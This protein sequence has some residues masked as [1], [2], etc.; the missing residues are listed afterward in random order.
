[1]TEA[2][3][4]RFRCAA[5]RAG[6]GLG[7]L[8]IVA[9]LVALALGVRAA[10]PGL[11]IGLTLAAALAN[12]ALAA[13]PWGRWLGSARGRVTLDLWSGGLIAFAAALVL[14]AGARAN[15]DLL[16]FLI[17]PF[18]A[19]TH[20]GR[21]RLGWLALAALTFAA[22][23]ALA[24]DPLT[25]DQIALHAVLL[26]AAVILALTLVR[27]TRQE[28]AARAQAAARAELE[29]AL[30]AESHHRVK[31]SLQTVADL[32][33][34]GRP[35]PDLDPGHA[36]DHTAGRIRSIAAV[37][38][39]LAGNLGEGVDAHDLLRTVLD[40]AAPRSADVGVEADPVAL[41]AAQ[42]Q[43]LGIV[44]N[45]L[46]VNALRHGAPPITVTLLDGDP[47]TLRV[48][49]HGPGPRDD[50]APGLGLTLVRQIAEH[51]LHGRFTLIHQPTGRT[52][53][54]MLFPLAAHARAHR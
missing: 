1:M 45:E 54:E 23:M 47:A 2:H 27:V 5:A 14:L 21:R 18:L 16:L 8:S 26:C 9:V 11:L 15:F 40:A 50:D 42:A 30:L 53:A 33:L 32:L 44:A 6:F 10:H 43:Q 12:T 24:P 51:G 22:V 39:L 25:P 41:D 17:G 13:V 38:H 28:A 7:V 19:I 34:L 4:Q 31:N 52:Q 29:H 20:E 46:V 48:E 49:D 3:D 35:T 36:F 37:H